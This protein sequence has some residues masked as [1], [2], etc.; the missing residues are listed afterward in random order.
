GV[1]SNGL[2]KFNND[3]AWT[4]VDDNTVGQAFNSGATQV[5]VDPKDPSNVYY[6]ELRTGGVALLRRSL[7]G[8]AWT[9][10]AVP[11]GG[12]HNR[13]VPLVIDSLTPSRLLLGDVSVLPNPTLWESLD[14]GT[15]W[16]SLNSP[17]GVVTEIAIATYQGAFTADPNFTLVTDKGT[18]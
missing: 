7:A 5:R 16:L 13:T 2:A 6:I 14:Q 4:F 8:G 9:T 12:P 3:L 11:T 1:Q 15:N 18:N 10:V 17:L